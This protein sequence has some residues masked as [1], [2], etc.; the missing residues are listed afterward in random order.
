MTWGSLNMGANVSCTPEHG[1]L[2]PTFKRN[3]PFASISA[4]FV[5]CLTKNAMR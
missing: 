2:L 3:I 4:V 5:T 1:T